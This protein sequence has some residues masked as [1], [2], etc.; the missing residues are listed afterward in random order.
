MPHYQSTVLFQKIQM[1][2]NFKNKIV[3]LEVVIETRP[4]T[5]VKWKNTEDGRDKTNCYERITDGNIV[6][7]TNTNN[8]NY[9]ISS[10][11]PFFKI[12]EDLYNLALKEK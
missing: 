9:L 11:N 2:S 5:Y 4:R 8:D 7:Y 6:F 3:D 10:H 1:D 12:L